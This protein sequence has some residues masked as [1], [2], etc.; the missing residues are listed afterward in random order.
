MAGTQNRRL[1]LKKEVHP[2]ALQKTVGFLETVQVREFAAEQH[3]SAFFR[4]KPECARSQS[5]TFSDSGISSIT[6][7]EEEEEEEEEMEEEG[8][9]EEEREEEGEEEEREEEREEFLL[10]TWTRSPYGSRLRQTSSRSI[11]RSH[12]GS[13]MRP[14]IRSGSNTDC[15]SWLTC[16]DSIPVDVDEENTTGDFYKDSSCTLKE[17]GIKT[18]PKE[19]FKIKWSYKRKRKKKMCLKTPHAQRPRKVLLLGDM[20]TGK[21]NLI[22]TYCKDRFFESYC[23]TILHFCCSDAKVLGRT[24]GLILVDTSGRDDFKPL[25]RCSYSQ[26][27]VAV[28][29]YSAEVR[30]SLERIRSHWLPEL[31][32]NAPNCP[33]VIAETK[34]DVRDEYKDKMYILE[35]EE[36]LEYQRVCGKMKEIVTE[37]MGERLAEELG[38]KGFYSTSAKYRI[39][40]RALFQAATTVAVKKSRRKR[41]GD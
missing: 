7:S 41:K 8:E 22:T 25:R 38:A 21:S 6:A 20:N 35:R 33:F 28:L 19:S 32:E 27:D 15:E 39:G 11:H 40:T 9:E 16:S 10:Q 17:E 34:C 37:G 18:I 29:C 14:R 26:T 13:G 24:F 1:K 4:I 36:D 31:R 12:S 3:P 5:P 2:L 30:G 23:P